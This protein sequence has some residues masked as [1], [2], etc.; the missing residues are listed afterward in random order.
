MNK[1]IKRVDISGFRSVDRGKVLASDV[2]IFSGANDSGKSN[3]L[4]A[5]NLFF[6]SQADFQKPLK[7]SDDYN[8]VSFAK[9]TMAAKMKQQIKVRVYFNIPRSYKSLAS[10]KEV[11]LERI[12]DRYGNRTEKYSN[13]E[14]RAQIT[15]L[16][17]KINYIYIPAL[18][19][20]AVLEHL[21]ALIGEYQLINPNSIEALNQQISTKT[22]DLSDLLNTSKISIGTTFGLP[23]FLSDF[24]QKLSVETTFDNYEHVSSTVKSKSDPQ[25]KLNPAQFKIPLLFR[26]DGIKSK[27][28]PPL[29]LWL[30]EKNK[31]RIYVWGIDEPENSLEFKLADELADL[32]FNNYG[33]KT[34]IFL[35]S[36]SLA[37]IN[38]PE[39]VRSSPV[40]YRCLKDDNGVTI[41]KSF[42][43]L[44]Q[45][46][47]RYKFYDEIG[48]L[49]VQNEV[50]D[51]YRR[52]EKEREK[53][54]TEIEKYRKPI[55]L[56]EGK[57]DARILRVAWKHLYPD[58]ELPYDFIPSGI[59][60][61]EDKRSGNA[62]QVKRALE[63]S[64]NMNK[65]SIII[66]LFDNDQ[67]G[68]QKFKGVNKEIFEEYNIE[69]NVRKHLEKEIYALLLPCP[70]KREIFVSTSSMKQRYFVIEHY[71]DDEILSA[72]NL[73]GD[74]ILGTEVFEIKGSSKTKFSKEVVPS[75][76]SDKFVEFKLLFKK[77]NELIR[78]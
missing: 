19:G 2:N 20:E 40:L 11:Y 53:L 5:L 74:N 47:E 43:D 33:L 69:K 14:K 29:L 8:K 75:L 76:S 15:K 3:I 7:F 64:A 16:V 6:N 39:N 70:V 49:E 42:D 1:I 26:G 25:K 78:N 57:T 73:K 23:V 52:V 36:H 17:N 62:D 38:P 46:E 12:F 31:S 50:M 45:K 63:L 59:Q 32:Y 68:N 4:R 77:L 58:T 67:E 71:F 9:A 61:D 55:V 56:T 34:Q 18:K 21:L 72:N 66:G 65:G 22:G 37:F 35:T 13:D 48:A 54:K 10:E 60:M 28:I 24:W 44:F 27:Y 41:I 30:N 51:T